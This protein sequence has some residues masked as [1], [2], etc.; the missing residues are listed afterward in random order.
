MNKSHQIL[1]RIILA[2]MISVLCLAGCTK[3]GGNVQETATAMFDVQLNQ[4]EIV[5]AEQR[6][7]ATQGAKLTI[8]AVQTADALQTAEAKATKDAQA[9]QQGEATLSADE[10]ATAEVEKAGATVTQYAFSVQSTKVAATAHAQPI[11]DVLKK[12]YDE[13]AITSTAGQLFEVDDFDE[14]WAQINWYKWWPVGLTPNRFVA[15][16]HMKWDTASNVSNWFNTGCGFVFD[17]TDTDNHFLVYLGLDG[18]A[19]IDRWV[20]GN[21]KSLARKYFGK[22]SVPSGEADVI[23]AVEDETITYYVNDSLAAHAHDKQIHRGPLALT[24]MSGTNKDYGTR[25]QISDIHVWILK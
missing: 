19:N 6:Q 3:A 9:T 16:A 23:L 24:L 20:N 22:V 2:G 13:S 14:S 5:L 17:A 21:A 11:I 18:Y 7:A 12:L 1:S 25:C 8:V 15:T 4:T 10:T